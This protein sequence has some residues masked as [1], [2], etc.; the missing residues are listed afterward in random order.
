MA[1]TLTVGTNTYLSLT[2]ANT[3]FESR[4]YSDSWTNASDN[5]KT[6]ALVLACKK[7]DR[8]MLRGKKALPTQPLEFPR[9]LYSHN[10]LGTNDIEYIGNLSE[11]LSENG[12]I[13]ETAVQQCVKDAQCEEAIAIL[14]NGTNANKRAKLQQQGV[15]SFT[16]GNMSETF[17]DIAI[18]STKLLSLEAMDL[19][20]PYLSGGAYIC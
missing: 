18:N 20:K 8:Q 1:L 9:R 2:N 3:Y 19:L 14:D 7:I 13:S 15:K 6:L 17:R 4:I 10:P 5:N 16:V 12:W 11:I